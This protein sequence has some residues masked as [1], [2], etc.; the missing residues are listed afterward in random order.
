MS[1]YV[2][3]ALHSL[4]IWWFSTGV[5][6]YLD[7]L[8]QRTFRW[9]MLGA[10]VVLAIALAGL[11]LSSADTTVGG[12]YAAF[13]YA[14]LAWSW[15]EVSFYLGY[16]TGPR[17]QTC[18]EGCGGWAH[19][20]HAI[21]ASLWHELAIFVLAA[22]VF[23]L[24]WDQP[25]QVGA[26]TFCVLWWMHQ[27]AKLNVF[28]GVRNLN[29]EFIPDHLSFLKS[30]FTKKP[31]NLL[32]PVSVTVSTIMAVVLFQRALSPSAT[33][34]EVAGFMNV[35]TMM[36]LAI[37]EHWLLVLPLPFAAIW[38]WGL[39]SRTAK[40][41]F[42]VEI[43]AGFLG[44]GKTTYLR[45]SLELADPAV[46]TVVLV[47]DFSAVGV[48]ASLLAGRGA[49]IVE[50]PNGCICCS[51]RKDLGKQLNEVIERW[52]PQRILIEPSGVADVAALLGVLGKPGIRVLVQSLRV[53][54]IIDAAAFLR[55]Y[56]RLSAYFD[57]QARVAH[58]VIVNK[59][60]LVSAAELRVVEHTLRVLNP[61]ALI[62]PAAYGAVRPGTF[63]L[64]SATPGGMPEA[65]H[66]ASEDAS[67]SHQRHLH[68]HHDET[69]THHEDRHE[70]TA[71]AFT[72]WSSP[73]TGKCDPQILQELLDSVAG[74]A[75]GQV[76]RVKGVARAGG[77]WIHFDIAGGRP[78]MA[79]FAAREGEKP[80]VIAI[81]HRVDKVRL[82]AAFDACSSDVA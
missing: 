33:A 38:A 54:T 41:K 2:L 5:V 60:D 30:F 24:T 71:L 29:E 63:D 55:D 46:R 11:S 51:L 3:P 28:L 62:V 57:A 73:L 40:Q 78:N 50:L 4:F 6:L 22:T 14:L 15:I 9:T 75:F 20:G 37:L 67:A 35:G 43:V 10:T 44:A 82:Q 59:T 13:T 23:L 31:M 25:N 18:P 45:R 8:P 36:A 58:A 48:D 26:W 70:P 19:F 80:R 21:M 52:S 72:S 47:N 77:G 79:A 27:S 64:L 17:T 42:D 76:E 65:E 12:A 61:T 74:G 32:F 56:S 53:C 1:Q 49:E 7:G 68:V 81:G 39:T 16:V 66:P 69:G 34:F